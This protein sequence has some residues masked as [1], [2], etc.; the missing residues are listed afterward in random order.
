M[1]TIFHEKQEGS[2]CA[3]HCLNAL[4]QETYYTA[5]DL[6][7]I[8]RQLDE[9]ERIRMTE[10]RIGMHSEEYKK[11]VEQ[12]SSNLDDSG[13]FSIQVI[14]SA[15]SA[16]DLEIISYASSD[17]RSVSAKANPN[18]QTAF[19]CNMREHWFT[20]RKLGRQWFNLNSLLTGPE[21]IS[22]TYLK[23]FLAQLETEG[24]SIHVVFGKLP[25]CIADQTLKYMTVVQTSKP[26]LI[27]VE[28]PGAMKGKPLTADGG[29]AFDSGT[30]SNIDDQEAAMDLEAAMALSLVEHK[31]STE[32]KEDDNLQLAMLLSM[33]GQ[34]NVEYGG[35]TSVNNAT[36]EQTPNNEDEELQ[37]AIA[38]SFGDKTC[39][40]AISENDKP[41][42]E[43][44]R[45]A[46]KSTIPSKARSDSNQNAKS[47]GVKQ[48]QHGQNKSLSVSDQSSS[49]PDTEEIRRRRLAFLAK[50]KQE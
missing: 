27:N 10:S 31:D 48:D 50:S 17:P 38:L 22:D 34:N 35:T 40:D 29:I 11:F 47:S 9:E 12:P 13:F 7:N 28:I 49:T 6:A 21:L 3:Q 20:I 41:S 24:Y 1:D 2:L 42:C 43:S 25:D 45:I 14:A 26:R 30:S 8:A 4:L 18:F 37:L 36:N 23:L 33:E 5:V 39:N 44:D 46:Q 16:W 32:M 19:I 15:I